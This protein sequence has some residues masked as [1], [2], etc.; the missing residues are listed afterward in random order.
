MF[1]GELLPAPRF[2]AP[3][4]RIRARKG[5]PLGTRGKLREESFDLAFG[6]MAACL[7]FKER[8]R[9]EGPV[10]DLR[11]HLGA[12]EFAAGDAVCGGRGAIALCR[13]RELLAEFEDE[14]IEAPL[15]IS[16]A[17]DVAIGANEHGRVFFE[18]G[19]EATFGDF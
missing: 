15:F 13:E 8:G 12:R 2:E 19:V 17:E 4:D 6:N 5:A 11:S 16:H 7:E 3:N 14:L 18:K 10:V 9:G 1:R